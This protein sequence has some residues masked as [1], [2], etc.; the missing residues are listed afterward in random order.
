MRVEYAGAIYHVMKRGDR[1]EVIFREDADRELF[2]ETLGPG[3]SA[4]VDGILECGERRGESIPCR[5]SGAPELDA[6]SLRTGYKHIAPAE[7]ARRRRRD[8]FIACDVRDAQAPA[9]RHVFWC[10]GNDKRHGRSI[11]CRSSGA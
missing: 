4:S 11:P 6:F 5:S 2:L 3:R 9:G 8:M 1:R 7:L 10:L